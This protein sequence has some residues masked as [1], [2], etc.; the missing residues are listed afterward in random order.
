LP[1][2]VTRKLHARLQ[3]AGVPSVYIELPQTEHTFDQF[4][5]EFSP[6]A[7]VALYDLDRFLALIV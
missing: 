7:Q 5:P 6:P 3:A 1:V 4:L 2:N